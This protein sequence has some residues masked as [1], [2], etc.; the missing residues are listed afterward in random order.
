VLQ[1]KIDEL[2]ID[3]EAA[4]VKSLQKIVG[5]ASSGMAEQPDDIESGAACVEQLGTAVLWAL[6]QDAR[7]LLTK[8]AGAM[9]DAAANDVALTAERRTTLALKSNATELTP[10][11]AD[12]QRAAR[13]CHRPARLSPNALLFKNGDKVEADFGGDGDYYSGKI[14]RARSDGTF[15]IWYEDGDKE[16]KVPAT[17]IRRCAGL[18]V[19]AAA[20][21]LKPIDSSLST[22]AAVTRDVRDRLLAV[23][24]KLGQ[25][26]DGS[27]DKKIA[28]KLRRFGSSLLDGQQGH[29]KQLGR[30]REQ[31]DNVCH[32]A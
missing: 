7:R 8:H 13:S 23:L 20:E 6:V 26:L 9:V 18:Q 24:R 12:G 17:R 11:L 22:E 31:A 21:Q 32:G 3:L 14:K 25:L 10:L 27:M 29:V 5:E 30:L 28:G 19:D 1:K 2:L 15:D 4:A 16:S